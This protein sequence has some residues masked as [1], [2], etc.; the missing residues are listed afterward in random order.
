MGIFLEK[1]TKPLGFDYRTNIALI[2]GF[3]AKEVVISTLG[4]AY[5][6]GEVEADETVSLSQKLRNNPAWNPL[7]AFTLIV[8]IMLYVPCFVT[9]ICIKRESSLRWAVFSVVFNLFAAYMVALIIR[10]GGLALGIGV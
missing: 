1:I 4:T 9:L 7:L 2:G 6:L 8:F 5:S 10:Q 3:A